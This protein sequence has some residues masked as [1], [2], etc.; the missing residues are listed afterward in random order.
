MMNTVYFSEGPKVLSP[1]LCA[2]PA[3]YFALLPAGWVRKPTWKGVADAG[4]KAKKFLMT[5]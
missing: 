5:V 1:Q 4:E 2:F 3:L